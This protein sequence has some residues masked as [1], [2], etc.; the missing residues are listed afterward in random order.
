MAK[1]N[2]DPM[3]LMW[4]IRRS[5]TH[6]GMPA[7]RRFVVLFDYAGVPSNKRRYWLVFD[8]GEV[9]LCMKDPGYGV[10]LTVASSVK[11]MVEVWLG[12]VAIAAAQRAR[13]LKFEG[14]RADIRAFSDWFS[15]SLFAREPET[16][17][18]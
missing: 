16:A 5:V 15:L 1:Q 12:H 17:S 11:T 3:L 10:D 9:D 7:G 4:D 18:A 14:T 8:R 2:L 13:D 6:D